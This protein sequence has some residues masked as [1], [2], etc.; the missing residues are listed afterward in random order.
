MLTSCGSARG[1]ISPTRWLEE[2]EVGRVVKREGVQ[3][4]GEDVLVIKG[5]V[6]DMA[7]DCVNYFG[8]RTMLHLGL[9][10]SKM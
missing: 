2:N 3:V 8:Q 7:R 9:E 10:L 5:V 4:P 1:S 6:Y